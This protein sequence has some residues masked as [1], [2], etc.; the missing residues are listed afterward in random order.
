M[1][2]PN[3]RGSQE[4]IITSSADYDFLT[5]TFSPLIPYLYKVRRLV[6]RLQLSQKTS[7]AVGTSF[8]TQPDELNELA[9]AGLEEEQGFM[10]ALGLEFDASAGRK[11]P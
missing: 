11:D 3:A 4:V 1:R 7:F 10:R 2:S 8:S 6:G 5:G 9:M